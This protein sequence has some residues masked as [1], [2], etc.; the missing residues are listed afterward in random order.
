MKPTLLFL[1]LITSICAN[2]QDYVAAQEKARQLDSY[3]TK[4]AEEKA[5]SG[6]VLVIKDNETILKK[7]YGFANREKQI[8][9]RSST[10]GSIGSITKLFTAASIMKLVEQGKLHLSDPLSLFFATVPLDKKDIT[11]HQLLTH[12]SG[13]VEFL[14]GDQ[15]DFEVIKTDLFL[16][17]AFAQPLAFKPGSK[18]IYTNVG[19]SILGIIIEQVSGMDSEQFL[20]KQLLEPVGINEIAYTYPVTYTDRIAVGYKNGSVWGTH[21]QRY[22]KAGGG[23]YWNLKANGGLEVSLDDMEKWV[24][25][26]TKHTVLSQNSIQQMFTK[27]VAEEGY[28]G[29]SYFGYGCNISKSRRDTPLIDNG[30]SNGIYHARLIRLPEE[31]LI[32]Y[33]ITNNNAV[34]A[35]LVMPNLTQLYFDGKIERDFTSQKFDHPVMNQMYEL[36]TQG[37]YTQF[38]T[39]LSAQKIQVDDDML[40]LEVGQKL[41][42]EGHL[43]PAIA[44]YQYYTKAFPNIVVCWNELGELYLQTNDKAAAKKCFEQALKL[45]PGNPRATENLKELK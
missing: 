31:K 15:G 1:F 12:S 38:E 33:V 44:L 18:A 3:L 27:Q 43:K 13:F 40:L 6:G 41:T 5:F 24:N 17:R 34:N 30:G 8:A 11:I 10:L 25:A 36:L 16:K 39:Q 35:N 9:Y 42:N 21:Q 20:K 29:D 37:D 14:E 23:P 26:F 28:G 2:S 45:R 32:F 7:G 4:L 19:M 22:E